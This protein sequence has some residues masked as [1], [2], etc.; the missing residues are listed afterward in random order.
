VVRGLPPQECLPVP[1]YLPPGRDKLA[2]KRQAANRIK[3]ILNYL[4]LSG[5]FDFWLGGWPCDS[6]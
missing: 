3:A 5:G 2:G 4:V 1:A 6:A